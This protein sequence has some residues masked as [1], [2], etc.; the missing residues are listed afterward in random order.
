MNYAKIIITTTLLYFVTACGGASESNNKDEPSVAVDTPSTGNIRISGTIEVG[1]ILSV[2]SSLADVDGPLQITTYQ[3][4]ADDIDILGATASNFT[5]TQAQTNQAISVKVTYNDS[6][7][8]DQYITSDKTALVAAA[9][10][11][12][13]PTTGN[14]TIS[15]KMEVGQTLTFDSSLSDDDGTIQITSFQWL[16]DNNMIPGAMNDTYTLTHAE[17]TTKISLTITFNDGVFT[18]E[19]ITSA[20]TS[21]VESPIA[22][23]RVLSPQS[24]MYIVHVTQAV[25][26]TPQAIIDAMPQ[27]IR[28][29]VV[30]NL[31]PNGVELGTDEG[32]LLMRDW[33]QVAKD[34]NVWAMVQP[35]AGIKNR[36][37]DTN[38]SRYE[39]LFVDFSNML[40]YNWS[41]QTW[42]FND[43][44]FK[45]RLDLFAELIAISNQYGGYLYI[46]DAL[47]I[48]NHWWN[49]VSKYKKHQDFREL[50]KQY[51]DHII[52]GNKLTHGWGYYD[53]ESMALGAYLAG[54]A[55]HYAIRYDQ[56]SWS[57]SGKTQLFGFEGERA[58]A[59]VY[60]GLAWI[61]T[62]EA[63]IGTHITEHLML[64]GASV[65]DGPEIEWISAIYKGLQTPNFKNIMADIV[66][67][68][69]DGTIVIPDRNAVAKRTKIALI[70]DVANIDNTPED[71]FTGVYKMDNDGEFRANRYWLKK[72]GRYPTIPYMYGQPAEN[73]H[74]E[75]TH[76]QSDYATEW[77]TQ[78]AKVDYLNSIYPEE[79]TGDMF[80]AGVNN[81]WLAYN[82]HVNT[83]QDTSGEFTLKYNTCASMNVNFTPHTYSVIKE[84]SQSLAIYVNN[85]RTD[86]DPLWAENPDGLSWYRVENIIMP[87]FIKN[88]PDSVLRKSEFVLKGCTSQ[89]SIIVTERGD[90]KAS[91][92]TTLNDN[93]DYII[94]AMHNGPIDIVVSNALADNITKLTVPSLKAIVE[95]SSPGTRKPQP[96]GVWLEAEC[97]VVG[98]S[99]DKPTLDIASNNQYVTARPGINSAS[100]A[101]DVNGQIAFTFTLDTD[102]DYDIWTRV[103]TPSANDDSFWLSFDSENWNSWNG[104]AGSHGWLWVKY[105]TKYFTAGNHTLDIGLREDGADLDKVFI[106][107][108]TPF[109]YGETATNVCN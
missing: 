31:N 71:L 63:L 84:N 18:D 89:P 17:S 4:L 53:N 39:Q 99:W 109:S 12:N 1:K 46:N 13:T 108:G 75:L 47:S 5:L 103:R 55:D 27:D 26:D 32:Y 34:N 65:I 61:T 33:L 7:Y 87:D 24:P 59:D 62:P 69:V 90:H 44:T 3:W 72:S 8:T 9:A 38:S 95:P 41:E 16:A 56:Y 79:A 23:R 78:Q 81:N 20:Q 106:G 45:Q 49:T 52:Y 74:Y 77:P 10:I 35:S 60:S 28:P 51:S 98:S 50:S 40:G 48:S 94:T 91:T 66:R 11:I 93:G 97:G 105:Q 36:M 25:G 21:T 88:P 19:T 73:E 76:K 85:Y 68:V 86:K 64:T 57:M 15:G 14:V 82:P 30:L 54:Y 43:D 2:T 22:F 101:P 96:Q 100:A 107:S 67:K 80:I 29:Y 104:I 102:G 70:N 42:G 37:D 6:V 92:V 83:N 58:D